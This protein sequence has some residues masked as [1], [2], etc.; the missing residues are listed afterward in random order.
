M[1]NTFNTGRLINGLFTD[2]NGN[3][4][5]GNTT[6]SYKLDVTGTGRFS[7]DVT[8]GGSGNPTLNITGSAGAYTSLFY[9]NA[10]GGGGSK[11]FANGGTNTLY[12][13][14]NNVERLA[15]TSSGNIGIGTNS[16]AQV[17]D[18]VGTFRTR[19]PADTTQYID[20][21][22]SGGEGFIDAVNSAAGTSQALIFRNGNSGGTTERM[23]ISASGNVGIGTSSPSSL[24]N[25]TVLMPD[26]SNG[27]GIVIR[28]RNDGGTASQPALT[29]LNGS[30]NY[31]A[32][33]VAD[34][35]T[36]YLGFNTGTSNTER[37][38]IDADGTLKLGTYHSTA[39]FLPG[40]DSN[41]YLRYNSSLDGLEM[42]GY[43]GVMF[44]TYGGSERMRITLNGEV[45]IGTTSSAWSS[46]NRCTLEVGGSSFTNA[47]VGLKMGSATGGYMYHNG[48][49][50]YINQDKTNRLYCI[51][52]NGGVYLTSGATSW[53]ANSDERLKDITGD[54]EN[55]VNSLMT[56]RTVKHT[57]K[58]DENKI[59]RLALIAQDVEKVFPQV[60][61]KGLL[62]NTPTNPNFDETEYLGVRYQELT[63][64]LVKAIQELKA[65]I[66]ILKNK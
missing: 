44:S 6:P 8:L 28:A 17:L 5:I 49:D 24:G 18:I 61:D 36:G 29:Y 45:L 51:A 54:I 46:S 33:I 31:I 25:L 22:S 34:N 63:P 27:T 65:E 37:M 40:A 32:Q 7:G 38:R 42:S 53:T 15:I 4:G 62:P 41:H 2:A 47:I 9:M 10:A 57:W 66:D 11:I 30:G 48:T 23:R 19:R 64:V 35:G 12:L 26:A 60:I 43:S 16:P 50:M 1:G 59:E 56:L 52:N 21:Y 55:A 3:V 14:T 39:K 13:G 20:V 58:T